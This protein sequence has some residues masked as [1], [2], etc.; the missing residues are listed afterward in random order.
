M[1]VTIG[2]DTLETSRLKSIGSGGEA[3]ILDI[4]GGYALK[5]FKGPKHSDFAGKP[6][7]EE[8]ARR[9]IEEHQD[10][11]PAFPKSMPASVICPK[12]LAKDH[13]GRIVGYTMPLV[14]DADE[15][16]LLSTTQYR[17]LGTTIDDIVAIFLEMHDTVSAIHKNGV[18]LGDFNDLNVLVSGKVPYFI[19][20]DSFQYSHFLCKT[21]TERF[22]DPLVC[23]PKAGSPVLTRPYGPECDWYAYCVMLMQSL[24]MLAGGPYGGVYMPKKGRGACPHPQRP[25]KRITVFHPDVIYPKPAVPLKFLPS[26]L[27][28]HFRQ[29][30]EDDLRVEFP[31]AILRGVKGMPDGSMVT[32]PVKLT[33]EIHGKVTVVPVFTTTGVIL[34]ACHQGG[35]LLWLCHEDGK[36]VREDRSVVMEAPMDRNVRFRLRGPATVMAEHGRVIEL[37]PGETPVQGVVDMFH[38]KVP[39]FDCNGQ[40]KFWV[41]GDRLVRDHSLGPSYGSQLVG[42]VVQGNTMFWV[43][44]KMGFGFYQAG[45][46]NVS[47]VFDPAKPGL[48]DTVSLPPVS[49]QLLDTTCYFSGPM[50]WFM[51]SRS[52][53]GKTLNRCH[54]VTA[55]GE[56]LASAE[57][58]ADD[59]SWLGGIRGMCPIGKFLLAPTDRGVVRISLDG[60]SLVES[61]RFA[62]TE[63]LVDS[64]S[65]LFPSSGGIYV[66]GTRDIR[67]LKMG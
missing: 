46:L 16:R 39:V 57:T 59:G 21:F 32:V 56:V 43:G 36:Y 51:T 64:S 12:A 55:A 6:E 58:E 4:G 45:G 61:Q 67:E 11:L 42:N 54:V 31:V 53:N 37:A 35:H 14:K 52:E 24:L 22:V 2:N 48:R 50:G 60:K 19:D 5:L 62:D 3:D 26:E 63:G 9:K 47:F 34:H 41:D 23:D 8:T 7:K 25:L 17:A 13:T 40:S 66:V 33:A 44:D 49:G 20:A 1:K 18:V 27:T 30:F 10:K 15:L 29:V 38:S 28:K 65:R